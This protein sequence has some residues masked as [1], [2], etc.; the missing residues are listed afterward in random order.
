MTYVSIMLYIVQPEHH[1]YVI[2]L[3]YSFIHMLYLFQV[4]AL[5]A[6]IMNKCNVQ[7]SI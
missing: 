4:G 1:H 3:L 5:F 2:V 7:Q 6:W